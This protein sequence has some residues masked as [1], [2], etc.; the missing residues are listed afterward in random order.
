MMELQVLTALGQPSTQVL[1]VQEE[2]FNTPF[3][4]HLVHEVVVGY[5]AG[6]RQGTAAQKTRAEVRGGGIKPWKQKGTGRAR[7]GSIRSPLWRA[8][9]VIFAAKPRSYTQKVNKKAY[10]KALSSILSELNRQGRLILVEHFDVPTA[11]TAELKKSLKVF[12]IDLNTK[13]S[14]LIVVEDLTENLYYSARN[15]PNVNVCDVFDVDPAT[16]IAFDKVIMSSDAAKAFEE[17][18]S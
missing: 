14:V 9:G 3:N 11:K 15:L 1:S 18:L 10:R 7:A 16:L 4:E 12:D 2:I 6:L 8:G 17:H 5:L 13:T